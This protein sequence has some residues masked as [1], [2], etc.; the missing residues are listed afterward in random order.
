ME[1]LTHDLFLLMLN[2]S[3]VRDRH[4]MLRVFVEALSEARAGIAVRL[5]ALGDESGGD[6]VDLSPFAEEPIR[7]AIE[8]T[9]DEMSNEVRA[10]YRNSISM[11]AVLLQNSVRA[12]HLATANARLDAAV[13][14]RTSELERSLKEIKDLYDHAPCG[15]H[16]LDSSGTYVRINDTELQWLGY[17]REEIVG[18]VRFAELLTPRNC[19]TFDENYEWFKRTGCVR[20]LEF[21]MVRKDGSILPVMLSATAVRDQDGQFIMT[22]STLVDLTERRKVEEKL[23]QAMKLEAVGRLAGGVAHDFNN[24]LT[25]ILSASVELAEV[26]EPHHPLQEEAAA[27]ATAAQRAAALTRQLLTFSR[28]QRVEPRV[29]DLDQVIVGME[30]MLRRIIG[31]DIELKTVS[32]AGPHRIL[33][34]PGQIDQVLLNLAV[35]ARDAM[36]NGGQ[37]LIETSTL[38][39]MDERAQASGLEPRSSVLLSIRDEG[40]GMGSDVVAH[41]FEPF[42]TTKEQ[43]KGTG[44]GLS[45]VYGIV[46]QSGGEIRVETAPGQ[47]TRFLIYLPMVREAAASVTPQRPAAALAHGGESVLVAEDDPAVR[48]MVVQILRRSGYS[49][50]EASNGEEA[51]EVALGAGR[52]DLLV[53][54]AVMPRLGGAALAERLRK[55]R[56]SLRVLFIS[57][58]STEGARLEA[59]KG[60]SFL[61]K[62]FTPSLL[63]IKVRELLDLHLE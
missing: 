34:D 47:G 32:D 22:R 42:F 23:R 39:A 16:S 20:D 12:E 13:A 27:I 30:R 31:E 25:V 44:L 40:V 11:L 41:L 19:M 10:L 6:V 36:P 18:R 28:R 61:Q 15:Y 9:T 49:V 52:V 26:L 51:L 54:D 4:A 48:R 3:R 24:L 50:L 38:L 2:L 29:I 45:T 33:A 57:G 46:K 35:N 43:G 56:P 8:G 60:I 55:K 7:I 5:L 14:S 37:L 58:Y 59:G 1:N 17:R 53:T 63:A 21:E 62:P